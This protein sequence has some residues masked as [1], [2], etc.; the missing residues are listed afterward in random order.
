MWEMIFNLFPMLEERIEKKMW[1]VGYGV[2]MHDGWMHFEIVTS[3][4]QN[5]CIDVVA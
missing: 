1:A 3:N 5:V 4:T 2:I